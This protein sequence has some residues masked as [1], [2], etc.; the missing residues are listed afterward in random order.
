[1]ASSRPAG[2]A[3]SRP[4]SRWSPSGFMSFRGRSGWPVRSSWR[5]RWWLPWPRAGTTWC[6]S[7]P[8]AVAGPAHVPPGREFMVEE[9]P[10]VPGSAGTGGPAAGELARAVLDLMRSR[11]QTLAVAESLTGGMVCA[12][13]TDI[14]GAS[15]V[16][17]GGIVAY[18]TDLKA[19][20]LDVPRELLERYGAVYPGVA[21]A[22]AEGAR[23]G[24]CGDGRG[25]SASASG[26]A[27]RPGQGRYFL[28]TALLQITSPPRGTA[29]SSA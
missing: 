8:Y 2:E 15:V 6:V 5:R 7:C 4:C 29:T 13:L 25:G 10:G 20:L 26:P 22:M 23:R 28:I 9:R 17:R 1:M 24:A 12:A 16:V 3:S 19:I 14:P 27:Y 18:A 21:A 11:G